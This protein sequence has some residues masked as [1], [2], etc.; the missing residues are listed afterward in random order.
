MVNLKLSSRAGRISQREQKVVVY[1]TDSS[2][3]RYDSVSYVSET[4]F[5][6]L[7][8]PMESVETP[9]TFAVPAMWG[10]WAR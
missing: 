9:R 2:G 8:H 1:L 10:G 6:M 3:R 7:L 4:P 5:S